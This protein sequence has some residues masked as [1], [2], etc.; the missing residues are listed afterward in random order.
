[1][2]IGVKSLVGSYGRLSLSDTATACVLT[3]TTPS[4]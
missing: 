3:V 2:E 1:M 4:V